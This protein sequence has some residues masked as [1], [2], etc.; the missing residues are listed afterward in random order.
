M[1][2][3]MVNYQNE[4]AS[5]FC[6]LILNE[7]QKILGHKA[8][9]DKMLNRFTHEKHIYIP[10]MG[11]DKVKFPI[12]NGYNRVRLDYDVKTR[13]ISATPDGSIVPMPSYNK[14]NYN[15]EYYS[16]YGLNNYN[17]NQNAGFVSQ[18]RE[19]TSTKY[20]FTDP[21]TGCKFHGSCSAVGF[22]GSLFS[23]QLDVASLDEIKQTNFSDNAFVHKTQALRIN[24]AD[25]TAGDLL[26]S[27]YFSIIEFIRTKYNAGE[28]SGVVV[29]CIGGHG[30]TGTFL[31]VV[32]LLMGVIDRTNPV[33]DLR[34]KYKKEAIET[35]GQENLVEYVAKCLD[36]G[37]IVE[38]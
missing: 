23:I 24:W 21:K 12:L 5:Y 22:V 15:T 19:R 1:M 37:L 11:I 10:L 25:R 18:V 20:A 6:N 34:N 7:S 17:Y 13:Q 26:S 4:M 33:T 32:G 16:S 29:N 3:Q 9:L 31:A 30:R 35:E 36:C 14:G 28:I 27:Q 38:V 8:A 2:M